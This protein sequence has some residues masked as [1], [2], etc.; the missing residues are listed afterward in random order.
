MLTASLLATGACSKKTVSFNS[1]PD[2]AVAAGT[3]RD[4]LTTARDTTNAPSLDTKKVV[5]T[6][7]QEKAAKEKK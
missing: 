2:Q 3:V 1:K 4:S 5:L 7:E 6:K